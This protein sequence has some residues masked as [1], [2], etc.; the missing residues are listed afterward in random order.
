M[1]AMMTKDK[2]KIII[3][4]AVTLFLWGTMPS[5]SKLL[6]AD[7]PEMEMLLICS[8]IATAFLLIVNIFTGKI[9]ALKTYRIKDY[10]VLLMLGGLGICL[11]TLFYNYGIDHLSSQ[12]A[13][14]INYMWPAMIILF[15]APILKE[16][17]TVRKVAAII[18]SF[19]GIV[20][21]VTRLNFKS[22]EIASVSGVIACLLAAVAYGIFS[23]LNKKYQ[24]DQTLA[25]MVYYGETTVV[26]AV[27]FAL[28]KE[29]VA[30]SG[31]INLFC[32]LWIGIG[33]YALGY[34]LWNVA[35]TSG[36]TAKVAN[37]AYLCPFINIVTARVVLKEP[38]SIYS[39][40]G[41]G[42]II[43]G[44]VIQNRDGK[45]HSQSGPK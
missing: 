30:I 28:S 11:Y 13:C 2:T 39:F 35:L 24:Y 4:V 6:F 14:I 12:E 15:S 3:Y 43:L 45:E 29:R 37:T 26:A 22:L 17:I 18:L 27:L 32:I 19:L 9:I 1:V 8:G 10:L 23:N 42:M 40:I 33:G 25:M 44:I 34:L 38:L 7:L 16:K 21:I 36:N 5:L 41:L 31:S 20:V